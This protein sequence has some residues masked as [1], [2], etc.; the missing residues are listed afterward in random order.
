MTDDDGPISSFIVRETDLAGRLGSYSV[1]G[2]KVE[3]PDLMPVV[4][5]N[6]MMKG[7]GIPP[8]ELLEN[9]GFSMI[10]TNSYI[11]RRSE[12]LKRKSEED[13]LHRLLDFPGIIMTDSGTFQS[14]MYGGG[15]G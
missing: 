15:S 10:I 13:G 1:N 11:I 9:F 4:N 2:R 14:Y 6:R 3:T 7:S 5:P 12:E 8:R